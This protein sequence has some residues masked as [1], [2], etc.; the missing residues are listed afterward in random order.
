V[1]GGTTGQ[2][3]GNHFRTDTQADVLRFRSTSN[4]ARQMRASDLVFKPSGIGAG[5]IPLAMRPSLCSASFFFSLFKPFFPGD[6]CVLAP[7]GR[8]RE[9]IFFIPLFFECDACS[10]QIV[11]VSVS[12]KADVARCCP[13]AR[14]RRVFNCQSNQLAFKL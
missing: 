3:L 1:P 7:V 10:A 12:K 14:L 5:K 8:L 2:Q 9:N 13:N 4:P 6:R 11:V